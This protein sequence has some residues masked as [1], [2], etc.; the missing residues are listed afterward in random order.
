MFLI[1]QIKKIRSSLRDRFKRS[2]RFHIHRICSSVHRLNWSGF[3]GSEKY[4]NEWK[5]SINIIITTTINNENENEKEKEEK[6]NCFKQFILFI[7]NKSYEETKNCVAQSSTL[8]QLM[9]EHFH[10]TIDS[11]NGWTFAVLFALLF[12]V[13]H[14]IYVNILYNIDKCAMSLVFLYILDSIQFKV[15]RT[16]F[17]LSLKIAE[18]QKRNQDNKIKLHPNAW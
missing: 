13:I 18:N 17:S 10:L 5:I 8:I 16:L 7:H 14:K 3:E 2:L 6:K 9:H 15:N 11:Y 4:E 12:F 1:L